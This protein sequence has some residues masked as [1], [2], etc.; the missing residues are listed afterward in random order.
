MN[1]NR[2]GYTPRKINIQHHTA[3]ELQ[4]PTGLFGG[5]FMSVKD[6]TLQCFHNTQLPMNRPHFPHDRHFWEQ[7]FTQK[8]HPQMT[9]GAKHQAYSTWATGGGTSAPQKPRCLGWTAVEAAR[10]GPPKTLSWAPKT[11]AKVYTNLN[12]GLRDG[13]DNDNHT[14]PLFDAD[15]T[16]NKYICFGSSNKN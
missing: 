5:P 7:K 12:L 6:D 8:I 4:F 10:A 3:Q 2:I 15:L 13:M 14:N 9:H 11:H 1:S 16:N